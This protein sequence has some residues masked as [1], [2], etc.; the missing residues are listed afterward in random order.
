MT[1]TTAD[2]TV[3]VIAHRQRGAFS[4]GQALAAGLS[5]RAIDTRLAGRRWSAL[6]AS[7]YA[8]PQ[9]P[10]TWE[11]NLMAAILGEPDAAAGGKSA[12]VLHQVAGF[13]PGRP[14]IVVSGNAQN[15]SPLALVRRRDDVRT[16][17]VD[18]IPSLTV[19]DTIF[20]VSG[21]VDPRR[22]ATALDDVLA[23]RAA[24]V[25]EIQERYLELAVRR[26]RGLA[27]LRRLI[28]VRSPNQEVPPESVLEARLYEILERPGMPRH[29]RQA[30]MS[31][32]PHERVDAVLVHDPVIIEADGRRW[33]TRV[34]DFERDRQRDRAAALHGYRTIRYTYDDLVHHGDQVEREIRAVIRIAA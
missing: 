1:S 9:Y 21:I 27:V 24:S 25:E 20:A 29:R 34:A 12:A 8:L 22:V 19:V 33:H 17:L 18:G 30:A 3:A 26:R 7:V 15:R 23:R 16:T 28:E 32:A 14:E 10:G 2:H 4:R 5:P 13:R 31:W 11:R 6:A